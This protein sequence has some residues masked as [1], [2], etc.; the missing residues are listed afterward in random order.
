[1]TSSSIVINYTNIYPAP[2]ASPNA[3]AQLYGVN[4]LMNEDGETGPCALSTTVTP[5][6]LWSYVDIIT[7]ITYNNSDYGA[8]TPTTPG[9][10]NRGNCYFCGMSSPITTMSQSIDLSPYMTAIDSGNVSF[11]LSAWLGGW[12]N[13]NDSAEVSVDFL[14]YAY[15]SVGHR[16][17]LG[18]VLAADRDFTTSLIFRQTSGTILINTRY[19][20]VIITLT[21]YAGGDNDGYIDN[22]SVELG[23]S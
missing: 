1:M 9:P 5:P 8:L 20:T 21:W 17:T 6:T 2:V 3:A 4:L 10:S 18:P 23:R 22:I 7:Q 14:N 12:T 11:H 16:T 15:Q 19:M 13:Q